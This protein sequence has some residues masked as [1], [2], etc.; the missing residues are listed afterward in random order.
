MSIRVWILSIIC[1][2]VS[3][4]SL[5]ETSVTASDGLRYELANSDNTH[6]VVMKLGDYKFIGFVCVSKKVSWWQESEVCSWQ[7]K[8]EATKVGIELKPA[9]TWTKEPRM[10][11]DLSW[12]LAIIFMG[13][14]GMFVARDEPTGPGGIDRRAVAMTVTLFSF[15]MSMLALGAH[16]YI[17]GILFSLSTVA[18]VVS[19]VF[20]YQKQYTPAV[21]SQMIFAS[22]AF[23]T[24]M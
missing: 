10:R 3:V 23:L 7:Q 24:V 6:R 9:G 17:Y 14:I 16:M 21:I 8:I 5:A 15:I 4:P 20:S 13:F 11:I 19:A 2:L 12:S 1:L 18:G 22:L